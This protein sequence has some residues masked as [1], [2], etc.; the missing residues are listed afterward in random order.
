ML[1]LRNESEA[2]GVSWKTRG[3]PAHEFFILISSKGSHNDKRRSAHHR[4][5]GHVG[6]NSKLLLLFLDATVDNLARK[7][8]SRAKWQQQYPGFDWLNSREEAETCLLLFISSY[9]RML[10]KDLLQRQFYN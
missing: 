5:V 9:D 7:D 2:S 6:R 10:L 3:C 4:T 8:G 1:K